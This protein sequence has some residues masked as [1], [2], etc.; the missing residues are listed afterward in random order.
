MQSGSNCFKYVHLICGLKL[1][2]Q[3]S[4]TDP[5]SCQFEILNQ[6]LSSLGLVKIKVSWT[7]IAKCGPIFLWYSDLGMQGMCFIGWSHVWPRGDFIS[8]VQFAG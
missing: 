6:Q 8:Y 7:I 4:K 5:G 2:L 1:A 3:K